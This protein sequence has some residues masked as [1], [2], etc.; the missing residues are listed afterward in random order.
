MKHPKYQLLAD[1]L[2]FELCAKNAVIALEILEKEAFDLVDFLADNGWLIEP[3]TCDWTNTSNT[4]SCDNPTRP[5]ES[6]CW[7]HKQ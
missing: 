6:Y 5:G 4:A 2:Y 1:D 3:P 7:E